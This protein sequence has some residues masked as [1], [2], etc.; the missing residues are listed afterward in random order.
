MAAGPTTVSLSE[1][2][3]YLMYTLFIAAMLILLLPSSNDFAKIGVALYTG[4]YSVILALYSIPLFFKS[5]MISETSGTSNFRNEGALYT[6]LNF[7]PNMIIATVNFISNI[8]GRILAATRLR[9][10]SQVN[11]LVASYGMV[12]LAKVV[13]FV[14]FAL[15]TNDDDSSVHVKAFLDYLAVNMIFH[16]LIMNA[17]ASMK[18][19]GIEQISIMDGLKSFFQNHTRNAKYESAR[20]RLRRTI[21]FVLTLILSFSFIFSTFQIYSST[22]KESSLLKGFLPKLF[23]LTDIEFLK[24]LSF[25]FGGI[26]TTFINDCDDNHS[27]V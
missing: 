12:S 15:I 8:T 10:S 7:V 6:I 27:K 17:D 25:E 3:R 4:I 11:T 19:R 2:G 26:D 5:V 9:K 22:T 24:T 23:I 16:R 14:S 13:L 18:G 1:I 20:M 21:L